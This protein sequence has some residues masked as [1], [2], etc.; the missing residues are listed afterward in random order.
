M[1]QRFQLLITLD[2]MEVSAYSCLLQIIEIKCKTEEER[3]KGDK[4]KKFA[5]NVKYA[6]SIVVHLKVTFLI[7][8]K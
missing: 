7:F 6:E 1:V 2:E 3:R 8:Q 4:R 5:F